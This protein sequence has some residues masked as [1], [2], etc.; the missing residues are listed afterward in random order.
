MKKIHIH[1]GGLVG[2]YAVCGAHDGIAVDDA[3]RA[4]C[5]KCISVVRDYV[6]SYGPGHRYEEEVKRA[7][8]NI[9]I[10]F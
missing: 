9:G 2:G 8:K 4:N 1:S 10:D 5:P 3:D 6:K 7:C